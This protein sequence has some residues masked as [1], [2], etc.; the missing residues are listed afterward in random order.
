VTCT[1]ETARAAGKRTAARRRSAPAA[2]DRLAEHLRA[3]TIAANAARRAHRD[4]GAI[5]TELGRVRE[6][7]RRA[8]AR[9]ILNHLEREA[10]S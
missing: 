2:D 7:L 6:A 8:E 10:T 3:L 5:A 1:P 4:G 9:L